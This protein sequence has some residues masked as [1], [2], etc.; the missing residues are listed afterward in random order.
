MGDDRLIDEPPHFLI[1]FGGDGIDHRRRESER[2]LHIWRLSPARPNA[3]FLPGKSY[4]ARMMFGL[5][6]AKPTEL[7]PALFPAKTPERKCLHRG[8]RS[9]SWHLDLRSERCC[10]RSSVTRSL[11]GLRSS[12]MRR[13]SFCKSAI[14]RTRTI[15]AY[16]PRS[17]RRRNRRT[18]ARSRAGAL[19]SYQLALA[20]RLYPA[21]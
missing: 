20:R 10:W 3:E 1:E 21:P 6:G 2:P 4:A 8:H 11:V 19:R 18:V 15:R 12:A 5:L 16:S 7:Q 14:T 9:P 13:Q 17:I